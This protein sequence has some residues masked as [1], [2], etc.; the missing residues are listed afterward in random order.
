MDD[1]GTNRASGRVRTFATDDRP[2]TPHK[3]SGNWI[4]WLLSAVVAG[5]FA[6]MVLYLGAYFTTGSRTTGG[7]TEFQGYRYKWQAKLFEPAV[8]IESAIR[9]QPIDV[10]WRT[11]RN[12]K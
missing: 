12:E 10:G 4:L 3:K 6:L 2:E 11:N 9:Q 8:K 7:P 1:Q 5:M